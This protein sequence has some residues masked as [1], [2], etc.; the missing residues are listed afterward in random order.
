MSGQAQKVRLNFSRTEVHVFAE[1][2]RNNFRLIADASP[3]Q[4]IIPMIKANAYGHGA[5]WAA[6]AL[7]SQKNIAAFGVATFLEALD[8][9]KTITTPIMIFSDTSPWCEDRSRVARLAHLQPVFSDLMNLKLFLKDPQAKTIS[10]H[11]ELNSGMNRLG[12]HFGDLSELTQLLRR[13]PPVSVFTHFADAENAKSDL[14]RLQISNVQKMKEWV[15]QNFSQTM[16]HAANSSAIWQ[17]SKLKELSDLDWVRPGLSLYGVLPYPEARDPGLK[18]VMQVT[19]PIAQILRVK[20]GESVGYNATYRATDPKGEC[21]ATVY[22]G[23][24]DGIFRSLSNS[25]TSDAFGVLE[26][27]TPAPL[28]GRVSMDLCAIRAQPE[29]QV[30]ERVEFW[31]DRVDPYVMAKAAGTNPYE[32]MTRMGFSSANRITR[33]EQ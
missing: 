5:T 33:H 1:A 24:A 7:K 27:G 18:R 12:I 29:T 16:V 23:Y 28:L 30:G 20:R 17:Q 32:I 13:Q 2:L 10:Y 6:S 15:R 22:G 4:L 26:N 11:V 3:G 19:S 14:T 9:R 31:G 8:I 25:F 21:V